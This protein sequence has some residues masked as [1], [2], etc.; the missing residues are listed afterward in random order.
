MNLIE[1]STGE[2]VTLIALAAVIALVAFAAR[3]KSAK[4][5][6]ADSNSKDKNG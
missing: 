4:T 5:E 6:E 1:V 3:R 2:L